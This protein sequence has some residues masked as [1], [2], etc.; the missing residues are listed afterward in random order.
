MVDFNDFLCPLL[1][2]G[3]L[4]VKLPT[5]W[6]NGKAVHLWFLDDRICSQEF[7]EL[8]KN[9]QSGWGKSQFSILGP[10]VSGERPRL[11]ANPCATSRWLPR[12]CARCLATRPGSFPDLLAFAWSSTNTNNPRIHADSASGSSGV[13]EMQ[14]ATSSNAAFSSS[15][16]PK[17]SA[18]HR[19]TSWR[20]SLE[21]TTCLFLMMQM[22]QTGSRNL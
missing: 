5:I 17:Q 22:I 15:N 6:T 16:S 11:L 2:E 14:Q 8:T 10:M 3:S 19:I 12:L 18:V 21:S 20:L 13:W 4:E 9:T 1:V 7:V